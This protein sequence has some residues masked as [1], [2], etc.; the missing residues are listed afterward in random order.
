M[1]EE[2]FL[3]TVYATI[4]ELRLLATAGLKFAQTHHDIERYTRLRQAAAQ[5]AAA[6]EGRSAE[7]ALAH[8]EGDLFDQRVS[9]LSTVDAVVM[10]EGR[11]LLIKRHDNGLWALPGG[12]VEVNQTLAEATL[13]ELEEETGIQGQIIQLLGIFDSR[14]WESREKV[15]LHHTIF[16]VDGGEQQPRPTREAPELGFFS[17]GELPVLSPG[18]HTRVPFVFKLLRG[19][20]PIPYVD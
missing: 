13:R 3:Q 12:L 20:V 4:N 7:A 6:V 16:L 17:E 9:P 10:R 2:P 18:H 8:F 14:L 19:E 15:H 1:S 11:I 5:L